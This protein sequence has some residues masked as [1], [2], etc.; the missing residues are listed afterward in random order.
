MKGNLAG[1]LVLAAILLVLGGDLVI[2]QVWGYDYSVSHFMHWLSQSF[3][4]TLLLTGIILGHFWW[5]VTS[6][7]DSTKGE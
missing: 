6:S 5:P 4:I 7:T 1:F 2:V 3:P